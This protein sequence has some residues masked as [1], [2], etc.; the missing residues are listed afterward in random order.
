M[1]E[2]P[3][4]AI[5]MPSFDHAVKV[6][7]EIKIAPAWPNRHSSHSDTLDTLYLRQITG[8]VTR[9]YC[10]IDTTARHACRYLIHMIFHTAHKRKCARCCDQIGRAHV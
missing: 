3:W 7:R 1:H 10:Y 8:C 6:R 2:I 9:H 4:R 5:G